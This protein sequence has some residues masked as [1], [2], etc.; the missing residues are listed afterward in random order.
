MWLLLMTTLPES[1]ERMRQTLPKAGEVKVS[2][3]RRDE[4]ERD[5]K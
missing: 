3:E 5:T 1:T 4:M 2:E